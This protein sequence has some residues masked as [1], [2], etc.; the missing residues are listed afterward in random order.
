MAGV[1]LGSRKLKGTEAVEGVEVSEQAV[2][3]RRKVL[4]VG[5]SNGIFSPSQWDRPL[6]PVPGA[7]VFLLQRRCLE[8]FR[9]AP[10]PGASGSPGMQRVAAWSGAGKRDPPCFPRDGRCWSSLGYG[11]SSCST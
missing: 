4:G 9:E 1:E 5:K 2:R 7:R 10:S 11:S 8:A 3:N 6:H